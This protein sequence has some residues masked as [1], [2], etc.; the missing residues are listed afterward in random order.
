M[1]PLDLTK[2]APRSPWDQ[3]AGAYMLPRTIDK[4]R[5][6]LPGGNVGA[7]R[8]PGFSE[9]LLR[10]IGCTED[11]LRDVVARANGDDDVAAWVSPRLDREKLARYNER[12]STRRLAD[13][14]DPEDFFTRYPIARNMPKDRT[15]FDMLLEDDVQ[16]LAGRTPG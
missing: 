6:L 1:E 3:L 7:Y 8:I 15:L 13:L 14:D 12:V 2:S 4:L 16:T 9:G 11:E 10:V 5:A